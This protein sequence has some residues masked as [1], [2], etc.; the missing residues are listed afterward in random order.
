MKLALSETVYCFDTN[1]LITLDTHYKQGK[2]FGPLWADIDEL[3]DAER[4]IIIEEVYDE[5]LRHQGPQSTWLKDWLK[6]NKKRF[7]QETGEEAMVMARKVIRE[8]KNT[9]F[10]K[11]EKML[12]GKE[13]A[14]PFLIGQAAVNGYVIVTE[15]SQASGN[16]IPKVAKKY[17]ARAIN[18]LAYLHERGFELTR[19]E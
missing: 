12:S 19:K 7:F 1:S 17:G 4:F 6:T 2:V 14:D 10:I 9:G 5:I 13:E 11:L 18:L 3:L 16:R 15:E 8:N